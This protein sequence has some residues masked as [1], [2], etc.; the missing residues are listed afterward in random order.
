MINIVVSVEGL[1][2]V[3]NEAQV[4]Y[5][6]YCTGNLDCTD[7]TY[8]CTSMLCSY[9]CIIIDCCIVCVS[10]CLALCVFVS[11]FKYA[12]LSVCVYMWSLFGAKLMIMSHMARHVSVFT[13]QC[14]H[15]HSSVSLQ[16]IIPVFTPLDHSTPVNH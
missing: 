16:L 10:V 15:Y 7:F 13:G 12:C 1:K 11:L 2:L 14:D 3:T 4:R 9:T 8:V 5:N 6:D